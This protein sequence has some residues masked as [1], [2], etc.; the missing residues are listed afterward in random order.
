LGD[1]AIY[2]TTK[3][4]WFLNNST[5]AFKTIPVFGGTGFDPAR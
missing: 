2:D 4:D 3:G 1:S 5:A